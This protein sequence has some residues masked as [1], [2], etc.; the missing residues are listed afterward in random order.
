[1]LSRFVLGTAKPARGKGAGGPHRTRA[2][3]TLPEGSRAAAPLVAR[4]AQAVAAFSFRL[5]MPV[6][7]R[8]LANGGCA[9]FANGSG[10]R[11]GVR[12][13]FSWWERVGY[14]RLQYPQL[15][16]AG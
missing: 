7:A 5:L 14:V 6:L 15:H 8:F 10:R 16:S 2:L 4:P 1:L 9:R 12:L 3:G 13:L 11:R